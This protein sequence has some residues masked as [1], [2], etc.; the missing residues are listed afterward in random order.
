[1]INVKTVDG[2]EPLTI[3]SSDYAE[4][5]TNLHNISKWDHPI[6]MQQFDIN[7]IYGDS[8]MVRAWDSGWCE[9]YGKYTYP[10]SLTIT[11]PSWA[12]GYEPQEG[13]I[14]YPQFP[15]EFTYQ[16]FSSFSIGPMDT[17]H[18]GDFMIIY[19]PTTGRNGKLWPPQ[20]KLWRGSTMTFGHP[21]I[22]CYAIGI[23]HAPESNSL[24]IF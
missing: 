11:K 18:S 19:S 20:F 17:G 4:V 14:T 16:P 15:I 7:T 21:I 22:Y 1:M 24:S 10:G 23:Y 5:K 3:D 13:A 12:N 9:C 8:W 2:S 6:M